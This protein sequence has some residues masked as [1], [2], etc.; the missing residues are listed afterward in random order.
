MIWSAA[1]LGKECHMLRIIFLAEKNRSFESISMSQSRLL[2]Y[3]LLPLLVSVIQMYIRK[4]P[5]NNRFIGAMKI[6]KMML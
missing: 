2:R 1:N 3:L 4:I 5:A 6:F